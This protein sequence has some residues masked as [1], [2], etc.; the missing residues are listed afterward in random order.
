MDV[1]IFVK[2]VL[3][4]EPVPIFVKNVPREGPLITYRGF[5][6]EYIDHDNGDRGFGSP[7]NGYT[8]FSWGYT[9]FYEIN[10]KG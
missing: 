7:V 3:K 8:Y 6:N 2:D 1:P 5:P 10:I 9:Y 4:G